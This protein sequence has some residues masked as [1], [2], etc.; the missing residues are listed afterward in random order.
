MSCRVIL[1]TLFGFIAGCTSAPVLHPV[2]HYDPSLLMA[3]SC[4]AEAVQDQGVWYININRDP[5]QPKDHPKQF[6]SGAFDARVT[7]FVNFE[8]A[9]QL[10]TVLI[11]ANEDGA[12]VDT[13]SVSTGRMITGEKI[14]SVDPPRSCEAF[15]VPVDQKTAMREVQVPQAELERT[16]SYGGRR[17]YAG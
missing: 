11:G 2:G 16:A 14:V 10:V 9:V 4:K 17:R 5:R 1:P 13:G 15:A 3:T 7:V 8:S 6:A 12:R